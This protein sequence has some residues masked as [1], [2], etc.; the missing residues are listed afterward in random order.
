M[1]LLELKI[2]ELQQINGGTREDYSTGQ[3]AG[4]HVRAAIVSLSDALLRFSKIVNNFI[5]G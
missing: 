4:K 1:N 5:P 3:S 2:D